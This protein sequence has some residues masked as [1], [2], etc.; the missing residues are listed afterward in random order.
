M[1]RI[2]IVRKVIL[3]VVFFACSVL[4]SIM[5][6]GKRCSVERSSFLSETY[7]IKQSFSFPPNHGVKAA[8][9]SPTAR[10]YALIYRGG[11]RLYYFK[12]IIERS[13][14]HLEAE[15]EAAQGK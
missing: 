9:G 4:I 11:R 14:R 15:M 5:K 3:E 7:F 2:F 1:F 8:A 12:C 6:Q 13:F 10:G